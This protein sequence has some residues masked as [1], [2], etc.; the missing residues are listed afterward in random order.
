ME[1]SD[2]FHLRKVNSSDID[3][4][5]QWA[6]DSQVRNNAFNTNIIP[7]DDHKEWFYNLLHDYDQ[8]Q[9]IFELNDKPIGQIRFVISNNEALI[10]YS[11]SY[12]LRGNGYGRKMLEMAKD[13]V[14]KERPEIKKLIGQVKKGN[15]ASSKCF[16][17][18]GYYESFTQFE[19]DI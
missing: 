18:C 5:F 8:I 6:N 9:Y 19:L 13:E 15:D 4:L 12:G 17:D 16:T 11:I 10:D 3:L 1:S 7:Y 14:I 2:G